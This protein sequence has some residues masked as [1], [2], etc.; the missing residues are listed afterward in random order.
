MPAVVDFLYCNIVQLSQS[1]LVDLSRPRF[2]TV[3][4]LD[5]LALKVPLRL[6]G[7]RM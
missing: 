2:P 4:D 1:V 5:L 3:P 6:E 7:C